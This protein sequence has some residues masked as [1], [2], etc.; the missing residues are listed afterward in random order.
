MIMQIPPV[1]VENRFSIIRPK[2]GLVKFDPPDCE[3]ETR[4]RLPPQPDQLS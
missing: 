4:I 1:E 3:V 2:G